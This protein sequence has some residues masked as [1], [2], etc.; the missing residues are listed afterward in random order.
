[1]S[2][3][4]LL[5]I[6]IHFYDRPSPIFLSLVRRGILRITALVH[7]I[8]HG[9]FCHFFD[10]NYLHG[11][12]LSHEKLGQI[13]VREHLGPLIKNPP[14]SVRPVRPGR[15]NESRSYRP[16]DLEREGQGQFPHSTLDQ[17]LQPVISEAT[18]DNLD[19]VRTRCLHVRR[20]GQDQ[21]IS[22]G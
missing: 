7:D 11:F 4:G 9:P 22:L 15:G 12:G 6:C 3:D 20:R 8:G 1:M 17:C 13:I 16:R 19:Y 21:S 10:D 14:R 5:V 2:P 18:A